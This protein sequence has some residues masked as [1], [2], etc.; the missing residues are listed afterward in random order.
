MKAKPGVPKRLISLLR[1]CDS[2]KELKR[3]HA[4][5]LTNATHHKPSF[6]LSKAIGFKD[7]EY[8]S[9]LF[10]HIADPDE[11]AFNVMIRGLTT[12]WKS[13]GLA[14][15]L[16]YRMKLIGLKPDK[17]TFPF[18][19]IACSNL[20]ELSH[21]RAAHSSVFKVG[22]DKDEHVSHSL[23]TAYAKCGELGCARNVFDEISER[24]LVSWNSMI[25]GYSKMGFSRDALGLF[26]EMR[27]A[28]FEPDETTL[29][30]ALGACGDLGDLSMG[31]WVEEF[32]AGRKLEINSFIGSSL[33]GMYGKCGDLLS[34]RRVFDSIAKKERVAWNALI[35]G[36]VF[37]LLHCKPSFFVKALKLSELHC[38]K[39]VIFELAIKS[40]ELVT[41]LPRKPI[42]VYE[43]GNQWAG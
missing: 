27:D 3:I 11:Y 23:I 8:S 2:I 5:I 18:F 9:S 39:M 6:L 13:F 12:T 16:Y 19:F 7:L 29:V 10:R 17:F 37:F 42:H 24:D 26:R 1:S 28:G 25:S 31:T 41:S 35:S 32:I 14:L 21:A 38:K 4:R 33:I 30:G 43:C 36:Q 40:T 34:A 20:S 22:L 15:A